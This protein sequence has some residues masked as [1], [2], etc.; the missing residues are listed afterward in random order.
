MSKKMSITNP[1]KIMWPSTSTTKA[2]YIAYLH[3]VADYVTAYTKDRLLTLIRYPGGVDGKS[4][5]QKHAPAHTPEWVEVVSRGQD[6]F[7][8]CNNRE[9]LY[10]LGNQAALELHIAFNTYSR[11]EEPTELVFDLD[12]SIEGFSHVREAALLMRD[13]LVGVGLVPYVK[14]SGATGLQIYVPIQLGYTYSDTRRVSRFI[15]EFLVQKHPRLLTVERLK[16]NRGDRLYIDYVQHA[17][18]KTLPAPY[19]TRARQTPTVSTPVAWE[20]IEKGCTPEDFTIYTVPERLEKQ[21]DL[22]AP[23]QSITSRQSL[24]A[25]LQFLD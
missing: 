19:S 8:V 7:I 5:Y 20:E 10:W 1:D 23:L 11:E 24:D 15:A 17:P 16:R 2:D 25:I 3:I 22:F 12:P 9:T 14:T 18:G 21:G 13:V 4:F 6:R